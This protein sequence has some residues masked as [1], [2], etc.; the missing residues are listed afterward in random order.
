MVME[1]LY[2][3]KGLMRLKELYAGEGLYTEKSLVGLC[4]RKI[5]LF[6]LLT[7]TGLIPKKATSTVQYIVSPIVAVDSK[8]LSTAEHILKCNPRI[9]LLQ[10]KIIAEVI[11]EQ[12]GEYKVP[13]LLISSIFMVESAY[14]I[15]AYNSRSKD[16]GIGQVSIWH[17]KKSKLSVRRLL[18]DLDYSVM[19][20]VRIFSWFYRTYPV[21]EAIARYNA[22]TRPGVLK[23]KSVKR[24]VALVKMY[25]SRGGE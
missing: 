21:E 6:F 23:W 5:L 4:G 19:H 16:Y 18:Y 1:E 12:A 15:D 9:G 25:W 7:L 2:T 11:D 14:K 20:A 10:A 22:G 24:Y 13:P 3:K 8:K 17:V